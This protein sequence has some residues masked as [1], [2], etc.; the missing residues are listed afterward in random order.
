M[1]PTSTNIRPTTLLP[2][3]MAIFIGNPNI[4][5][6]LLSDTSSVIAGNVVFED[7]SSLGESNRVHDTSVLEQKKR[8][9]NQRGEEESYKLPDVNEVEITYS[10][11]DDVDI[12]LIELLVDGVPVES[13]DLS[14]GD[15]V[16]SYLGRYTGSFS[17]GLHELSA[18]VE[19]QAGRTA[20]SRRRQFRILVDG[21]APEID[22][23]Y[24]PATPAP[25]EAVTV[26]ADVTDD[27]GVKSIVISDSLGRIFPARRCDFSTFIV[28]ASCTWVIEP[29]PRI[30]M[31]GLKVFATDNE[32]ISATSNDY[33][34]L[35]GNSGP[36]RDNDGLADAIEA[37]L[38]TDPNSPDTDLDGLS[39]G[40]EITGIHF[41]NGEL[42][43]L[44]NY[45][46]H[47]CRRDLLLQVDS[48]E[49][50]APSPQ[51]Y[52]MMR[53]AL[54][55]NGI[56][57]YLETHDRERPTVYR[58][59]HLKDNTAVYQTQDGEYYFDPKRAWAFLY[60]YN[61]A[62][63]G[64]GG[65]GNRFSTV[66]AYEG[67]GGFCSSGPRQFESCRGDFECPGTGAMCRTGCDGGSRRGMTCST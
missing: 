44:V 15:D 12:E 40:W 29:D 67:T 31:V 66:E 34:V 60:A 63:A 64:A 51:V 35:F 27:S 10:A 53:S 4:A 14:S 37:G 57:L 16:V 11:S 18:R 42:E 52:D 28:E 38:C 3:A 8:G 43:P 9:M 32:D 30:A 6:P 61:R 19:D 20:F 49:L 5:G 23:S 17:P 47:P 25:G 13:V 59:S 41:A 36:D 26:T 45:G 21:E 58:Q 1:K 55:D 33:R 65:G 7:G 56:K 2:T 62:A 50:A 46:V 54:R 39:D 24:S 48:E 22:L